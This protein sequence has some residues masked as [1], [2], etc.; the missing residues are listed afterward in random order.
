MMA[1]QRRI[2]VAMSGGVD[3]S[4]A[5]A[6]LVERGESVFGLMMR[7]WNSRPDAHNRCCSPAD[8]ASAR[9]VAAQLDIPFYVLDA[10]EAFNEHVVVPFI[11]GYAHGITP[12]PCIE[13]N[14]LIRWGF[15]LRQALAF[16][17]THLATGHY[18]QTVLRDGRFHLLRAHDI[19]KDQSYVL[20]VLSQQDLRM[21]LFPLGGFTK[22]Q[23]R[24]HARR[25]GLAV[26]ERKDSQDL[27]FVS[28]ADYRAFLR[29]QAAELPPP[30]LIVNR[31]GHVL[32][33]HDG[34]AAF[35]IGQ[36]KGIRIT[37]PSPLYVLEKDLQTNRLIVGR[38]EELGRSEFN[39]HHVR[40]TS[41][42]PPAHPVQVRVRVRYMAQEVPGEVRPLTQE[43]ASVRLKSR[44]PDITP[45]QSAVFYDGE[46]CLGGGIIEA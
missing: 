20:Y 4:T 1:Q 15:L 25:M 33:Q 43:R 3:S 26:A 11:H 22:R 35:T 34:L 21:T 40:W 44:L 6:L 39:L 8:I 32:G 12:N 14:R 45:G 13:C 17:A 19:H 9:Q 10:Q 28:A 42:H 16:G 37:S 41:D 27:C 24:A 46:E 29:E 2:A 7:L 31:Q 18:S 38:Q 5:A 30:G 36:R 23:V